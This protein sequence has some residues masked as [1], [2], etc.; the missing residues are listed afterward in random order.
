MQI[1]NSKP[2]HA[3][4]RSTT[5]GSSMSGMYPPFANRDLS[6]VESSHGR[7]CLNGLD[8]AID[9]KFEGLMVKFETAH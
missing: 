8:L 7:K 2:V 1:H 4:A 9:M 5:L 3:Q 6:S